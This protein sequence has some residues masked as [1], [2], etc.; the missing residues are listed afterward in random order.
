MA[1]VAKTPRRARE[2]K[3]IKMALHATHRDAE[4]LQL[5]T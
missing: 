2:H 4:K 5:W 3:G 1:T